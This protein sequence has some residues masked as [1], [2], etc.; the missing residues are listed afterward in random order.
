MPKQIR[1]IAFNYFADKLFPLFSKGNVYMISSGKVVLSNKMYS[2]I[3][4]DYMIIMN[5]KTEVELCKDDDEN[6]SNDNTDIAKQIF[7]FVP[8]E[9]IMQSRI[10]TYV[11]VIGYVECVQP[12]QVAN[13]CQRK[14]KKRPII[15]VDPSGKIEVTLWEGDAENSMKTIE[16]LSHCRIQRMFGL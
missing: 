1:A 14:L 10:W 9:S 3:K 2:Q 15:L 8:I 13:S 6:K 7:V 12:L 5:E 11:D 16:M 4:N